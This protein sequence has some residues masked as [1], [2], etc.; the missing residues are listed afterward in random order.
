MNNILVDRI[1]L[2]SNEELVINEL[3]HNVY[4]IKENTKVIVN[5]NDMVYDYYEFNLEENSHLVINKLYK[6]K[7]GFEEI[8]VNLN[9]VNSKIDYNFGTLVYD[10]QKYVININHNNK[11]T[12]SNVINHGVVMNDS[13]LEFIVNAIVKKGNKKSVLNQESK[14]I[15]MG[16]NNSIIR[17]NLFVDEYDVEAIHAATIGR[18]NKEEIFYLMTKGINKDDAIKLLINGFLEG[19]IGR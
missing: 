8:N 2:E 19:H 3:K 15:V 18:F 5:I 17:P 6:G 14:I 7:D 9:G 11:N 1:I 13:K 4:D 12:I 16:E 10:D